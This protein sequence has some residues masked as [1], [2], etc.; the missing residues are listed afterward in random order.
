MSLLN[1]NKA[2]DGVNNRD[3][4]YTES[5]FKEIEKKRI[6]KNQEKHKDKYIHKWN[7]E[8]K[9]IDSLSESELKD[10]LSENKKNAHQPR[11]GKV[12]LKVNSFEFALIK[13]IQMVNKKRSVR[14]LF[15][16]LLSRYILD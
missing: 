14:E 4:L 10:F 12:S 3:L 13:Y 8:K 7:N 2:D 11:V 15:V 9:I 6:K 16:Y 1:N 5:E